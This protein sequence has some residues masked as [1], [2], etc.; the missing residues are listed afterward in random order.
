M[1]INVLSSPYFGYP[2]LPFNCLH[3][4][5]AMRDKQV[6]VV[7]DDKNIRT[8]I[9]H[10]LESGGYSVTEAADGEEAVKLASQTEFAAALLDLQMPRMDGRETLLSLKKSQPELQC[11]MISAVGTIEDAVNAMNEGAFW[12]IQKPFE[13]EALLTLVGKAIEV[14]ALQQENITLRRSIANPTLPVNY[15]GKS[16]LIEH[17]R[18]QALKAAPL[19]ST[20]L[21]SG[22]SGTGKSTLTKKEL[23]QGQ[24][25]AEQERLKLPMV[26]P[27]FSMKL[28]TCHLIYSRSYSLFYKTE[29]F[30]K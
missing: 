20:V 2:S 10:T 27:C 29:L 25:E 9:S 17:V 24:A 1:T 5:G 28:V 18:Q 12:F 6:L 8:L 19:D 4:S 22:P 3:F 23:L 26:E 13:P 15:I 16:Q 7:D 21:L 30:K 11:L 14:S